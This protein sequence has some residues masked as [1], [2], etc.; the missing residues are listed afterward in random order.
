[1]DMSAKQT[2]DTAKLLKG[3]SH[4]TLYPIFQKKIK[5]DSYLNIPVT[6]GNSESKHF[7]V[8][9]NFTVPQLLDG[10]Q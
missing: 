7:S 4:F 3:R 8:W 2:N 9:N 6:L 5:I 10:K 1:M